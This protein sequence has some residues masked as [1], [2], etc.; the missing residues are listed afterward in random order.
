MFEIDWPNVEGI[1]VIL[2]GG[3]KLEALIFDVD[4]TLV[5]TEEVHRQAYNQTFLDFGFSREWDAPRYAELLEI[6]GGAARIA[7]FIDQLDLTPGEKIPLRRVIPGIHREKTRLRRTDCKQQRS[8][9][10]WGRATD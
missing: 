9:A 6:S 4:G 3:M 10:P 2:D 5:H 1:E 8:R 7:A